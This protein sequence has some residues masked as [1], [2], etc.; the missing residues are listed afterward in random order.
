MLANLRNKS[1]FLVDSVHNDDN[2]HWFDLID[3]QVP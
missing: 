1:D 2:N 3:N